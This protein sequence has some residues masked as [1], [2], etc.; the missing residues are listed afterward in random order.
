MATHP[1]IPPETNAATI[2]PILPLIAGP[3][4]RTGRDPR[5]PSP[6]ALQLR[7]SAPGIKRVLSALAL[8]V[9]AGNVV[10]FNGVPDAALRLERPLTC[11]FLKRTTDILLSL[12]GIIFGAPLLALIALIVKLDSHGPV[13]YRSPR[14]GSKGHVF[15][16]YKFR[17]M[18]V[19]ADEMK[20][21]LRLR[22]ERVGPFFKLA[23]DPR[24][25]RC[26]RFLRRYSLDEL[27]QLWNVLRGD[28]SLVGPRPHPV[29]DVQLYR[30]E[31]LRRLTVTPGITGLWQITARRDPS[32]ERSIAL[33]LEY[34]EHRSLWMDLKVLW[35]TVFV[36]LQGTGA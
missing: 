2:A 22:N 8:P 30:A 20:D 28:M 12:S 24:I 23:D 25:T 3:A 18:I 7:P 6:I 19:G 31:H 10:A 36:V 14:V 34:I 32:F 1:A 13:L 26:G 15:G 33:D 5:Q 27:P 16:C 9:F 4:P 11:P 35:K 29:D 21:S 17:T